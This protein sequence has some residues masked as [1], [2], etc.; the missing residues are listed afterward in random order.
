MRVRYESGVVRDGGF[1]DGGCGDVGFG[2]V[3]MGGGGEEPPIY[4]NH[5]FGAQGGGYIWIG[6]R[7]GPI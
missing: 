3:G 1:G 2:D 4:E 7:G 5:G 6:S